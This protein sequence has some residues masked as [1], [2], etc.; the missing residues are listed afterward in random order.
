MNTF[1]LVG[2]NNR[3]LVIDGDGPVGTAVIIAE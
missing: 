2:K 3:V 1:T